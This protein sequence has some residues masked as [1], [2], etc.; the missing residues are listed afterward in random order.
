MRFHFIAT[1]AALAAISQ[2]VNVNI[3]EDNT[4]LA[5]PMNVA[6]VEALTSAY[7]EAELEAEAEANLEAFVEAVL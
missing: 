1:L 5:S 4:E 6:E 7:T 3:Q 2:A